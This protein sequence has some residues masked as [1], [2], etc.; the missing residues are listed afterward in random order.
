M[1][2]TLIKSN[3]KGGNL[4]C[5]TTRVMCL[6]LQKLSLNKVWP[7]TKTRERHEGTMESCLIFIKIGPLCVKLQ[8]TVCFMLHVA[9]RSQLRL[10]KM[11]VGVLQCAPELNLENRSTYIS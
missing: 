9:K 3:T 6:N 8:R 10:C 5:S 11:V 1:L 2:R 4:V 7:D